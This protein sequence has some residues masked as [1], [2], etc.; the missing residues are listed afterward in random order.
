MASRGGLDAD[1]WWKVG[2]GDPSLPHHPRKQRFCIR[3]GVHH[4]SDV[5]KVILVVRVDPFFV[6]VVDEEVDVLGDV[7]WLDGGEVDAGDC[8]VWVFVAD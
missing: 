1:R 6:K 3:H 4:I 5:D 8:G 7:V 2:G